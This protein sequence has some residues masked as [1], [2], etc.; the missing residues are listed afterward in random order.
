[1]RGSSSDT[2]T[3]RT[4][5][6]ILQ[7]PTSNEPES[8]DSVLTPQDSRR[9]KAG[10][11]EV[12][13]LCSVPLPLSADSSLLCER[14]AKTNEVTREPNTAGRDAGP[15]RQD[16]D[17]S[18]RG[19]PQQAAV[20]SVNLIPGAEDAAVGALDDEEDDGAV[21]GTAQARSEERRVGKE[22]RL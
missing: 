6:R 18:R 8:G 20:V 17:T 19:A 15:I 4:A 1:M 9:S 7:P 10:G 5:A 3:E 14:Q 12:S 21:A 13:P 16:L 22:C 2:A 11:D